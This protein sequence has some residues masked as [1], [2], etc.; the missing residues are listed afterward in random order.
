MNPRR[1][2]ELMSNYFPAVEHAALEWSVVQT[3]HGANVAAI[4]DL[5]SQ[6]ID[7]SVVL[8]EVRRKLAAS[9]PVD[10]APCYISEHIGQGEIRVADRQFTGFVVVALNGVASGWRNAG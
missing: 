2:H 6:H 8:I 1:I 5:L 3:E 4:A 7:S 9:L 10:E